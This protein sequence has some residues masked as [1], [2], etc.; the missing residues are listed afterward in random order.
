MALG[1]LASVAIGFY[2]V[3]HRA[4]IAENAIVEYTG[5]EEYGKLVHK[6][7]AGEEVDEAQ[8][9]KALGVD[10]DTFEVIESAAEELGIDLG[11]S[12]QLQE[13][14]QANTDTAPQL[15][16]I[17]ERAQS[18]ELSA[19]EIVVELKRVLVVP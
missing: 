13:I 11:D 14:M 2:V 17:A 18:G 19:D 16:E 1:I 6:L 10:D 3:S 7:L 12:E 5:N 4:D 15:E 9:Q 8:L